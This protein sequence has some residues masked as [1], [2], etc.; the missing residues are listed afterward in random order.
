MHIRSRHGDRIARGC[1]HHRQQIIARH[2]IDG[3]LVDAV[4]VDRGVVEDQPSGGSRDIR[5]DAKLVVVHRAQHK[6]VG[7]ADVYVQR[8][9]TRERNWA[10][11]RLRHRAGAEINRHVA[12]RA[13]EVQHVA[14]IRVI[15]VDRDAEI[16]MIS[17]DREL[18]V[19]VQAIDH[20]LVDVGLCDRRTTRER[21]RASRACYT[22]TVILTR[23]QNRQLVGAV[24]CIADEIQRAARTEAHERDRHPDRF[25]V[26][27]VVGR[28]WSQRVIDPL[29]TRTAGDAERRRSAGDHRHV[30]DRGIGDR[31]R[32]ERT[33]CARN[34]LGRHIHAYGRRQAIDNQR[35][36][37]GGITPQD[38]D[39]C[40]RE[41]RDGIVQ[42]DH[43]VAG[44][45]IDDQTPLAGKLNRLEGIDPNQ[46]CRLPGENRSGVAA[47][48][49]G[50]VIDRIVGSRSDNRQHGG[51]HI[52][53]DRFQIDEVDPHQDV[54][55]GVLVGQSALGD[56]RAHRVDDFRKRR[57]RG[58]AKHLQGVRTGATVE[59]DGRP[60][61]PAAGVDL[62]DVVAV[63][64]LDLQRA[65]PRVQDG[66]AQLDFLVCHDDWTIGHLVVVALGGTEDDQRIHRRVRRG[67]QA[68]HLIDHAAR[69]TLGRHL[70]AIDP[71]PVHKR[72]LGKA[73]EVDR[74][75]AID[76]RTRSRQLDRRPRG[77]LPRVVA[78]V[79][80]QFQHVA[81]T[82]AQ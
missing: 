67:V 9:Q 52:I 37:G 64:S 1:G 32:P 30:L 47:V 45:G 4:G 70:K 10:E 56:C 39:A 16:R 71:T 60:H 54:V 79:V 81:T 11:Q 74:R 69:Q 24:Q 78:Q 65:E 23:P 2:A 63:Q 55:I 13:E 59:Q 62:Q 19:P 15:T 21:H 36:A 38:G 66:H 68:D 25:D 48:G 35:V 72:G 18:I 26:S 34:R 6:Q 27:A 3:E 77:D 41:R 75:A 50:D 8:L 44:A 73:L 76:R 17:V 46:P 57:R 53:L 51:R 80:V 20:Q 31:H 82:V 40:Q 29:G 22:Q 28:A 14:G 12:A 49:A 33:G 5:C 42:V 7:P 43:I 61:G 58:G